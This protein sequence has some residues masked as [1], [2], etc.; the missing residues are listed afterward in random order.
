MSE[1]EHPSVT[2]MPD[3]LLVLDGTAMLFRAYYSIRYQSP[4]GIEV[5]AM[6][7]VSQDLAKIC[8]RLNPKHVLIAFDAGQKTFRNDIDPRYKANRGDPP[9]DLVPQFEWVRLM[10]D[11]LGFWHEMKVGVEADDIMATAAHLARASGMRSRV[12]ALDKDLWQLVDDAPPPTVLEDPRT[13]TSVRERDV[14]AKFQIPVTRLRDYFALVGDSSDNIPGAAGVGPKAA[15]ALLQHFPDIDTM[16]NGLG[17]VE[18]L[19]VRGAK[20]LGKKVDASRDEV[21]LARTLVSLKY[22]VDINANPGTLRQK[23]QWAGPTEHAQRLF[24][25]MGFQG[26][27]PS[28]MQ[29]AYGE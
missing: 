2:A 4:N 3:E 25:R 18:T 5:G 27:L 9:E 11:T 16:Y 12:R 19:S 26:G 15:A 10:V 21:L 20:T 23:S 13:N 6:L 29:T 22:D 17:E 28:L 7:G 24:Q 8:R 1:Q 14:L